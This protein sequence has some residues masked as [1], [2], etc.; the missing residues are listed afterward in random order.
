MSSGD[1]SVLTLK[2]FVDFDILQIL[3]L[4]LYF[5]AK[6]FS[7]ELPFVEYCGFSTCIEALKSFVI[8]TCS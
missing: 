4:K 5:E 2:I 6:I 8:G 7:S 3:I 1:K